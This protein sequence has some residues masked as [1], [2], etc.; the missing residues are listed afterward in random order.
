MYQL[1]TDSD[2][3]GV[4]C[5]IIA[6]T[7]YPKQFDFYYCNPYSINDKIKFFIETEYYKDYDKVFITDLSV[8]D[9]IKKMINDLEDNNFV[10]IDHHNVKDNFTDCNWV[11][12][13]TKDKLSFNDDGKEHLLCGAY[14]FYNYLAGHIAGKT[15]E[16]AKEINQRLE[17]DININ[18]I[19]ALEQ[20]IEITRRY[21]TYEWKIIN[22]VIPYRYKI[23][24]DILGIK[25]YYKSI[26]KKI[27][28]ATANLT[29][30]ER[31]LGNFIAEHNPD[32]DFV[33]MI[34]LLDKRLSFRTIREDV[35]VSEIANLH[36]SG[37]HKKASGCPLAENFQD[38]IVSKIL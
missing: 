38:K 18:Q 10:L 26:N 25:R 35:D 23:L 4:M 11:H 28:S 14:N 31:E 29:K 13:T 16:E 37:G 20:L 27:K 30:E 21:D 15:K 2:N 7:L 3:D 17:Y 33:C 34:D 22:D 9:E 5:A 1:F 24:L 6:D 12:I 19:K 32:I 36:G 8:N